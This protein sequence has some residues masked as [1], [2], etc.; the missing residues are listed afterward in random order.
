[1]A[2][3]PARLKFD[4][5]GKIIISESNR[6][7]INIIRESQQRQQELTRQDV[8]EKLSDY[9]LLEN[10]LDTRPNLWVRYINIK[11]GKL[12]TG[13]FP[14]RN[15]EN[16]EFIVL[17]NISLNFT[18]SIKRKDVLLFQKI[19]K[20][21]LMLL[22]EKALNIINKYESKQGKLYTALGAKFRILKSSKTVAGLARELGVDR[23]SLGKAYRLQKL[24]F[25]NFILFKLDQ[26]QVDELEVDVDSLGDDEI[27]ENRFRNQLLSIIDL[28]YK[29]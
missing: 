26:E 29:N 10:K 19:P 7:I 1:M 24:K 21:S 28:F 27:K 2:Q 6:D 14:I 8:I 4:K 23:K 15:E 3:F 17:K 25:K 12:R 16:E 20:H 18:F 22:S 9:I 11:D 5:F 13:G